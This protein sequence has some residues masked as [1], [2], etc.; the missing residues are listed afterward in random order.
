MK[1][2]DERIV[3]AV[4]NEYGA[5]LYCHRTHKG[6]PLDFSRHAYLVAI[7]QDRAGDVVIRKATQ[8][9]VSEYLM[10]YAIAQNDQNRAVFWVFP[11]ET[12]RNQFIA[13]RMD[14]TVNNTPRYLDIASRAKDKARRG[15]DAA[16]AVSLKQ[17]GNASIAFVA[18]NSPVSFK[19]FSADVAI[20]DEV[21]QCDGGNLAMLPDRLAHSE[22]RFTRKVGNPTI[23]GYGID[24]LYGESDQ[25]RWHI[26]C[27]GC[28]ERQP[29]DW[30]ANVVRETAEGQYELRS[31]ADAEDA[32]VVC[33]KCQRPLDRFAVGEWV[34]TYPGRRVSGYHVSQLFSGA[35]PMGDIWAA[36]QRGLSN[37]TE[38][39]RFHN[40]VLGEPFT[41]EGAKLS[42]A[43]L[44]RALGD[45]S[46]QSVGEGCFMGVDVG[47]QLHVCV[48]DG[49]DRVVRILIAHAF[50]ELDNLVASFKASVVIDALPETREARHFAERH[51]GRVLL[52]QFVKS[53]QVRDFAVDH[54]AMTIKADRT[55]T[56]DESHA[57]ILQKRVMLPRDALGVPDFMPQMCAPTRVFDQDK[58]V[59]RWVEGSAPDH[60]R[61]AF[62]YAWICRNAYARTGQPTVWVI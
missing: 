4:T 5:A 31:A 24:A 40:S 41:A 2:T 59:F 39:Q 21:D 51:R 52:C 30:F 10:A 50:S 11:T 45:H 9:G 6:D 23:G 14:R 54:A 36:F 62:N 25:K 35:V 19:S 56:L 49:N 38:A 55:Q 46:Q 18:S 1:L 33:R 15:K 43:L 53:D 37:A 29:L 47:A 57:A 13:D 28:G 32:R 22:F 44:A 20:V 16:D 12:L 17:F 58:Q 61:H 27:E 8:C 7:Y 60:Y 34:A 42:E 3:R 48:I 26:R